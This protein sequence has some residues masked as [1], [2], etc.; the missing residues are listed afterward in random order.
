MRYR[1][2]LSAMI[3]EAIN[4][5]DLKSVRPVELVAE[6]RLRST[7]AA[8]YAGSR[9]NAGRIAVPTNEVHSG[10]QLECARD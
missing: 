8:S 9:G 3:I 4:S 5:V 10:E 7:T 2:D 6:S 1:G